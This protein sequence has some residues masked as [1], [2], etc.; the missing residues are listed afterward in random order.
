M[1]R[2]YIKP[3]I[4][5]ETDL[6]RLFYWF[7]LN[8]DAFDLSLLESMWVNQSWSKLKY[9]ALTGFY[10]NLLQQSQDYD[11]EISLQKLLKN[12]DSEEIHARWNSIFFQSFKQNQEQNKASIQ[13]HYKKD[14]TG[15]QLFNMLIQGVGIFADCHYELEQA[16]TLGERAKVTK[17][18][19]IVNTS[20]AMK[21]L[22]KASEI[23]G[24]LTTS[25]S[26]YDQA[27]LSYLP[28]YEFKYV[29]N[30]II[31]V[32]L[33]RKEKIDHANI[34]LASQTLHSLNTLKSINRNTN[35]IKTI[36][37]IESSLLFPKELPNLSN[38]IFSVNAS[39]LDNT[40]KPTLQKAVKVIE[41]K[42]PNAT[43][44][45]KATKAL[46]TPAKSNGRNDECTTIVSDRKAAPAVKPQTVEQ[47]ANKP[48]QPTA[49][50][51]VIKRE[52]SQTSKV[53]TQEHPVAVKAETPKPAQIP[54]QEPSE[55]ANEEK[56]LDIYDKI[57]RA[58]KL[59]PALEAMFDTSNW[60]D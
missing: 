34:F 39:N 21:S 35:N 56:D 17:F 9:V 28:K 29:H 57:D 8:V 54:K 60:R 13:R 14:D 24:T 48:A 15:L 31:L 55:P 25:R 51:Q 44:E 46:A 47:P 16:K 5:Q 30:D 49:V 18:K 59:N 6:G 3:I 12:I 45:Q 7:N 22:I 33:S 58:A 52:N 40:N 32:N 27:I 2:I 50:E 19:R 20:R 1:S 43:T 41:K 26:W 37:V 38:E 53:S 23:F 11:T 42:E 36:G 4:T 10:L